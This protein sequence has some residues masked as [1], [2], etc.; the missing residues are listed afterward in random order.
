V[1]EKGRETF[2][3]LST[4]GRAAALK[5]ALTQKQIVQAGEA[6]G[7][8]FSGRLS[9]LQDAAQQ[10]LGRIG[11][12]LFKALG[13]TLDKFTKWLAD[14][15][16]GINA[17]AETVGSVLVKAFNAIGAAFSWLSDHQD[18]VLPVLEGIALALGL[19]AA[20]AILLRVRALAPMIAQFAKF[21]IAIEIFKKLRGTIG[22]VG[23][24]LVAAFS[25][26]A[27]NKLIGATGSLISNLTK[28]AGASK[29]IGGG[30]SALVPLVGTAVALGIEA[31][32]AARTLAKQSSTVNELALQDL[33]GWDPNRNFEG[34][35]PFR[36][37]DRPSVPGV[38]SNTS[39]SSVVSNTNSFII[40]AAPG[41][42]PLMIGKVVD[43]KLAGVNR[44]ALDEVRGGRR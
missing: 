44:S 19:I 30:F 35:D 43:E 24:A 20:Q 37:G 40:N 8:S 12:G 18:L 25:V 7:K 21:T 5:A 36:L 32:D 10:F 29:G 14:N 17:F 34:P 26:V 22:D 23:A 38:A 2:N 28:A 41:Q 11:S 15:E 33:P 31:V 39:T 4:A 9:T 3:K 16:K 27:I 6:Q 42:D 1:G 13:P